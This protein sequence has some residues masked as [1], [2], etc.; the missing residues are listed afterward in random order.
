MEIK[1]KLVWDISRKQY[2]LSKTFYIKTV[3]TLAEIFKV[4]FFLKVCNNLRSIYSRKV[5]ES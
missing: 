2:R 5:A 3:R 4:N 1:I